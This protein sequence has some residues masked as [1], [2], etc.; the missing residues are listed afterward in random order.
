MDTL[1][2]TAHHTKDITTDFMETGNKRIVH[3]AITGSKMHLSALCG[4][5][6]PQRRW[7]SQS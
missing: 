1:A 6:S 3:A 2:L 5:C 4:G 7:E